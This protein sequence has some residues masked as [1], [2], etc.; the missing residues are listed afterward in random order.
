MSC[1]P[2]LFN[3]IFLV[4]ISSENTINI[5]FFNTPQDELF[6]RRLA[7]HLVSLYY[8]SEATTEQNILDL[9]LLR[10]YLSYAREQVQPKL[11]EEASQSLISAYV[12]M[13]KVGG[14]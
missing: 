5:L 14:Y 11:S 4:N 3:F 12:D 8:R 7:R 10:D 13:R 1:L 9:A 6:D 2:S